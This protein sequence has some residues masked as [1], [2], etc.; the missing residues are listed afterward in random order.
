MGFNFRW[1]FAVFNQTLCRW[2]RYAVAVSSF[3]GLGA[4]AAQAATLCVN[5]NGSNGCVATIQAAIN[6]VSS[7][8]TTIAVGPGT[9]SATTCGGP[10]CSVAVI[11]S[12]ASNAASLTGLTLRC[13]Q[14]KLTRSV[15]L[16]ATGL[17][18]A[19]YVS[20]VAQVTIAGC[21][22]ENAMREGILVE[23][24]DNANVANNEVADNDQAM[25]SKLGK[26]TPPC[27]TFLS[28]GTGGAIQCCPDAFATGPGNFPND[29]DDCGEGIHLRAVTNSVV[30]GNFVHDNIGGILLT[31]ETGANSSNLISKNTSKDNTKFGGD[32]GVTLASHVACTPGSTDVTGCTLAPLGS[33]GGVFH[34]VVD[35]NLLNHNGASGAGM[36]ANPGIP[37]GSATA[38]YGNQ[39]SNNTVTNNGQPGIAIH[40]HAA[41]GNADN[42]VIVGN[43]VSGN[44]G[45]GEATPVAHPPGLGIE[46][47]SNGS[48]GFPFD[49]ASPIVGTMISHNNVSKQDI[50]VWVG[51]N[52]TDAHVTLNNL[53]GKGASGV[54]NAGSGTVTAT[55]NYWGCPKGPNSSSCTSTSG[56]VISSPFASHPSP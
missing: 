23:N 49:G 54:T 11:S 37:P 6:A 8:D 1:H 50:D 20:G 42:N 12:T 25:A 41:N 21:V 40:V 34:N 39:I 14:G 10:G 45:D 30:Q 24:S 46:V 7:P 9:Y 13:N 4:C 18:H 22:A 53:V 56:T 27:P 29:N 35:G 52:A 5:K 2:V 38:A 51:N 43:A 31:D 32:C 44:G 26:G 19:V 47:L 3:I 16:D 15:L 55:E 33:P 28:P 17:N 36:F 48:F